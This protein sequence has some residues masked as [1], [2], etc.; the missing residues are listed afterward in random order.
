[1]SQRNRGDPPRRDRGDPPRRDRGDPSRHLP[2]LPPTP[3]PDNRRQDQA[4]GHRVLNPNTML[5]TTEDPIQ[6]IYANRPRRILNPNALPEAAPNAPQH[7]PPER[8][9]GSAGLGSAY[10]VAISPDTAL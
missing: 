3:A 6:P 10:S 4:R 2:P 8:G 7:A 9:Y 5:G 1:M